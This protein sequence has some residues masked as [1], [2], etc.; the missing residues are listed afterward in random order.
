MGRT[1][2]IAIGVLCA[3]F[4]SVLM[5]ANASAEQ[6]AF[7]CSPEAGA[8]DYKDAH[9]VTNLGVGHGTRGHILITEEDTAIE[10]TNQSTA[11]NTTAAQPFILKGTAPTLGIT[12]T[13]QCT[14]LSLTGA[15]TNA[16][17]SVTAVAVISYSG[18]TVA[19]PAG[20][21]CVVKG[22]AFTTNLLVLTTVG[23]A[24]SKVKVGPSGETG[25]ASI[26]IEKC[27]FAALN[28]TF[29]LAGSFVATAS[30]ATLTTTHAGTTGLFFA[31]KSAGI[32]GAMTI[33]EEFF[34]VGDPIVLT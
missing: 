20:K 24:A 1:S 6:R 22:G 25:L 18:C 11:G 15:L 32:E 9:C 21:G 29:S 7:T 5:A 14:G 3:L 19:L 4:L 16:A 8:N 34:G 26:T 31:G 2:F 33:R 27:S 23:Q 28:S 13:V 30:G 12:T 17:S 10:G